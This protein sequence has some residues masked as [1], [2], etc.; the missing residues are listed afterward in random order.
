MPLPAHSHEA[1]VGLQDHLQAIHDNLG[2][3]ET[4]ATI[5]DVQGKISQRYQNFFSGNAQMFASTKSLLET[6]RDLGTII[7]MLEKQ[8]KQS[9]PARDNMKPRDPG[10][11]I[12]GN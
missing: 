7:R 8:K 9:P 10:E 11:T 5:A 1:L 4:Q 2:P 6:I 12:K 3:Q